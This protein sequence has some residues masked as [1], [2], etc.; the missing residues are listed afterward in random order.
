[1]TDDLRIAV[2]DAPA[3]AATA[4]IADGL[5]AYNDLASGTQGDFRQLAVVV[6]DPASGAP[7]GGLYGRTSRG[8]AF[9]DRFF[10]P[11]PLRRNGLGARV[12]AMAEEEGRRRG[13]AVIALFTLEFQA[14]GFYRKQG[15]IEAARLAPPPPGTTRYLM[16]KSLL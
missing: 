12:L 6:T 14:P 15:Y 7:V 11:E 10:L 1:M 2:T 5:G 9:I 3:E 8:V 16:T 13:C 4:A